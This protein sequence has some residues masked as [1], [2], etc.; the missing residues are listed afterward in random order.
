MAMAFNL[1]R[2]ANRLTRDLEV[3]VNRP[4]G[5]SF[6]G[7]RLLFTIKA[8]DIKAVDGGH[9]RLI[10]NETATGGRRRGARRCAPGVCA[11]SVSS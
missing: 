3:S 1:M 5:L 9:P 10:R 11:R 2:A 8:V 6:A 4:N 7:Y